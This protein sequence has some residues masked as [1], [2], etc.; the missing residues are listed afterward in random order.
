MKI[1]SPLIIGHRGASGYAPENTLA[2]FLKAYELG[3]KW[4]ECDVMLA[5]ACSE[6]III[7]DSRLDRTTNLQLE[8]CDLNLDQLLSIDAGSWFHP[9]FVNEKIP[10]LKQ[11]MDFL[12]Q[13]AM[14]AVLEL[15]PY[16]GQDEKTAKV[17]IEILKNQYAQQLDQIVISSFS[18]ISLAEARV[19]LPEQYLGFT[20][21]SWDVDWRIM[22]Q[23]IGF[24]S[25]HVDQQIL[26][27]ERVQEIKQ[28][29]LDVFSYTVNTPQRAQE[30][31]TMGV[32][33][34]FSDFPDRLLNNI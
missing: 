34:I 31:F 2:S 20:I 5:D 8:V 13:H 18:V 24:Q 3:I 33:A 1:N 17:A 28:Y 4:I 30:L 11:T 14:S 25:L 9:Q 10:T 26:T 6:T 12:Q 19:L 15:K 23:E 32:D 21:S 16:P 29:G 7:H 27:P 22:L